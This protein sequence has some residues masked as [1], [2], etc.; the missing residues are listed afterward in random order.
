MSDVSALRDM[1]KNAALAAVPK[2]TGMADGF[3]FAPGMSCE[4]RWFEARG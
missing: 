2:Q 4:V 1:E 3:C